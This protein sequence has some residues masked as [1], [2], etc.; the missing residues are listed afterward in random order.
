MISKP[1]VFTAEEAAEYLQIHKNTLYRLIKSGKIP[2][3]K[4]G[5]QWRFHQQA[6][7]QW[8]LEGDDTHQDPS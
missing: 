7:D 1:Q 8:L 5:R 6:L 3:R 4:V 2:A